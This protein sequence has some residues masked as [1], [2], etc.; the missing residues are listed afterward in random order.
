MSQRPKSASLLRRLA[1]AADG[2]RDGQSRYLVF[3]YDRA[4]KRDRVFTEREDA[5]QYLQGLPSEERT[6]F[7]VF[8]PYVSPLDQPT[9]ERVSTIVVEWGQ[10]RESIDAADYDS[11]FWTSSAIDKFLIPYYT[12]VLGI[13]KAA[14]LRDELRLMS[15]VGHTPWSYPD[16]DTGKSLWEDG[17]TRVMVGKRPEGTTVEVSIG[18]DGKLKFRT[19]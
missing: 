12:R 18:T 10:K 8:G 9:T 4:D 14:T 3:H 7:G 1:E 2:Y 17:P 5:D 19:E 6:D 16:R 11:L 13:S 15:F